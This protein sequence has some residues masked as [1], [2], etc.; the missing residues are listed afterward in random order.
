MV[1]GSF[2]IKFPSL[3]NL[4]LSPIIGLGIKIK[5]IAFHFFILAD[6]AKKR[7]IDKACESARMGLDTGTLR[8]IQNPKERG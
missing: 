4:L 5:L 8:L 7:S 2:A 3:S 1:S 6:F